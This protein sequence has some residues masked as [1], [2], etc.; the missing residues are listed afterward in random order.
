M[1]AVV[2]AAAA[3]AAAGGASTAAMADTADGLGEIPAS[4]V[5]MLMT[6]VSRHHVEQL[7]QLRVDVEEPS[8]VTARS[9]KENNNNTNERDGKTLKAILHPHTTAVFWRKGGGG[10]G[11][12]GK[13]GEGGRGEDG[14]TSC[15]LSLARQPAPKKKKRRQS[16]GGGTTEAVCRWRSLISRAAPKYKMAHLNSHL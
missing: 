12:S 14:K 6:K 7:V 10:G 3:G 16:G 9:K 5:A 2:G 8:H 1:V 11:E 13:R 15:W 4:L